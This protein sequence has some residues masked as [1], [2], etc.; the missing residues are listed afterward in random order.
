MQTI[1]QMKKYGEDPVAICKQ[2]IP[3]AME[4][5][6]EIQGN[7]VDLPLEF[8]VKETLTPPVNSKEGIMPTSLWT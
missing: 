6:E 7:L 4:M 2:N 3:L 8:L 5:L 1:A